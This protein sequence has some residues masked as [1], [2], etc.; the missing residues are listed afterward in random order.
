MKFLNVLNAVNYV[1]R[2][3]FFFIVLKMSS[4]VILKST[5]TNFATYEFI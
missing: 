2:I 5:W 1:K 3:T 4:L